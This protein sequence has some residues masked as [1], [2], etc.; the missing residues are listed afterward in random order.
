MV[1]GGMEAARPCCTLEYI[2]WY[3]RQGVLAG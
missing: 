2:K 3:S 1:G